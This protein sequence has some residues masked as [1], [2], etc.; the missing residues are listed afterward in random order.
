M[1]L[2]RVLVLDRRILL[3]PGLLVDC[4]WSNSS[5]DEMRLRGVHDL[6]KGP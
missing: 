5:V 6:Q 2:M 3:L 1:P 4:F